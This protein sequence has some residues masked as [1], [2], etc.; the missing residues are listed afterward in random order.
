MNM[1]IAQALEPRFSQNRFP[2]NLTQRNMNATAEKN[3]TKPKM[4]ARRRDE[5]TEVK[6]ADWKMMGASEAEW[7]VECSKLPGR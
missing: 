1:Q 4:P 2:L 6:P 7:S 5:E 3:L